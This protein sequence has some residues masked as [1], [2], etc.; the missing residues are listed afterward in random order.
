MGTL[1]VSGVP[2]AFVTG[3]SG[4]LKKSFSG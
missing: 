1:T 3:I 4:R 2:S